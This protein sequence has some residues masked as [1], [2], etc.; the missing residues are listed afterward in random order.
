[1]GIFNKF[2]NRGKVIDLTAGKTISKPI[3]SQ[4][5]TSDREIVDLSQSED[6]SESKESIAPDASPLSFL[7]NLTKKPASAETT[8]TTSTTISVEQ[9]KKKLSQVIGNIDERIE[10]NTS[11]IYKLQQDI[12]VLKR[13]LDIRS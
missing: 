9:K 8:T 7:S 4:E 5:S 11:D 6:I 3:I 10:R 12:E 1:M 2:K 13:K